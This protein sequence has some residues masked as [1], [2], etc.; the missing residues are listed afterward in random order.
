MRFIFLIFFPVFLIVLGVYGA[1]SSLPVQNT[2]VRGVSLPIPQDRLWELLTEFEAMGQWHEEITKVTALPELE[3]KKVLWHVTE[4][5][6]KSYVIVPSYQS[7]P[8]IFNV[9]WVENSLPYQVRWETSLVDKTPKPKE[10]EEVAAKTFIKITETSKTSNPFVRFFIQYFVGYETNV[11]QY[12]Q[13]LAKH[14]EVPKSEI[15]E[16]MA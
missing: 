11:E 4:K 14:F 7:K 12:L 8:D 10:K 13:N 15:K 9:E 6:Q 16:L 2:V 3:T 1:G 5:D